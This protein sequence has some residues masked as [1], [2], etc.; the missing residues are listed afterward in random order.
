MGFFTGSRC[1]RELMAPY[2]LPKA[3]GLSFLRGS[4]CFATVIADS[5]SKPCLW[6]SDWIANELRA[7]CYHRPFSPAFE[8]A[9]QNIRFVAFDEH[10]DKAFG[11][12]H[13]RPRRRDVSRSPARNYPRE[14]GR[15]AI[16]EG[17]G[18]GQKFLII[19]VSSSAF[20]AFKAT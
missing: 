19:R 9:K 13:R 10:G 2:D 3:A 16:S 8:K 20:G 4:N 12:R 15:C 11:E 18:I 5:E 17:N 7:W 1:E 14:S 6:L